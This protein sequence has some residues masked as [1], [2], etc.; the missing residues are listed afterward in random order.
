LTPVRL[1]VPSA[2]AVASLLPPDRREHRRYRVIP[3]SHPDRLLRHAEFVAVELP[4]GG[5]VS[6]A[7]ITHIATISSNPRRSQP[8]RRL[9]DVEEVHRGALRALAFNTSAS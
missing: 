3:A 2:A 4:H 8:C 1:V 5:V 7:T 9:Q 6:V